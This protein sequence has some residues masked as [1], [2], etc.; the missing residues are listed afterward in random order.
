MAHVPL[1]TI[2]AKES[3]LG[4]SDSVFALLGTWLRDSSSNGDE[5]EADLT[6]LT[7]QRRQA[8]AANSPP[9]ALALYAAQLRILASKLGPLAPAAAFTWGESA[10]LSGASGVSA[11]TS[12]SVG[13]ERAAVVFNLG[14]ALRATAAASPD[15]KAAAKHLA[16]AAHAFAVPP[17]LASANSSTD[18]AP[19]AAVALAAICLADAQERFF[20]KA[21]A[22][23]LSNATVAKLA[24]GTAEMYQ[25]AINALVAATGISFPPIWISV[26]SAKFLFYEAVAAF[27]QSRVVEAGEG[28]IVG[29]FGLEVGY[30]RV[31]ITSLTRIEN[32]LTAYKIVLLLKLESLESKNVVNFLKSEAKTLLEEIM[33]ISQSAEKDNNVICMIK[34]RFCF[35]LPF[36]INTY[37]PID[38]EIVPTA[39]ELPPIQ[40]AKLAKPDETPF[41]TLIPPSAFKPLFSS[42]MPAALSTT[43]TEYIKARDARI[44]PTIEILSAAAPSFRAAIA[45]Q[46]LPD[47]IDAL[48]ETNAEFV[49]YRLRALAR[50]VDVAQIEAAMREVGRLREAAGKAVAAGVA[51]LDLEEVEDGEVQRA[52]TAASASATASA[53]TAALGYGNRGGGAPHSIPMRAQVRV[54]SRVL[55][56]GLRETAD[57]YSD[58][59][60]AAAKSDQV[61]GS[62]VSGV[63]EILC[64][65]VTGD[66]KRDDESSVLM[67]VQRL[68][69]LSQLNA[70]TFEKVDEVVKLR[71]VLKL[72][73]DVLSK[74][75]SL[76]NELEVLK[77]SDD[78]AT[79][80]SEANESDANFKPDAFIKQELQK[81]DSLIQA[82]QASL[83][84]QDDIMKILTT[85]SAKFTEWKKT[86]ALLVKRD[87]LLEEH[88]KAS[89]MFQEIM[90]NL[91]GAIKFYS[92]FEPITAKFLMNCKDYCMTRTIEKNEI[93]EGLQKQKQ[94]VPVW[95]GNDIQKF[96]NVFCF[97]LMDSVRTAKKT[98]R[99]AMRT[100]LRAVGTEELERQSRYATQVLLASQ[101]WARASSVAV[102]LSTPNNEVQ[103]DTIVKAALESGRRVFVPRCINRTEMQMVLLESMTALAALKTNSLGIR[104]PALDENN[105]AVVALSTALLGVDLVVVPG[106]AFDASGARLGHGRGYYDRFLVKLRAFNVENGRQYSPAI[107]LALA[108]QFLD[109]DIPC[110]NDDVKPDFIVSTSTPIPPPF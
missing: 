11:V 85:R 46:R 48:A 89:T 51:A 12:P 1:L 74:L 109:H 75:S 58:K 70:A 42:L 39:A 2:A 24:K 83:K 55:T 56:R 41:D 105:D 45:A 94:Q 40:P 82:S 108:E 43:V 80:L 26:L 59:L 61:V 20:R 14:A 4:D 95:D 77:K 73:N 66:D 21:V 25:A 78:I 91:G 104:E 29:K 67:L 102:Y 6:A 37:F 96:T 15:H 18:F 34:P 57:A 97:V 52:L 49:T 69:L 8:L 53:A 106:L 31:A 7:L 16:M 84:S 13:F 5:T 30:L 110:N 107:A 17:A 27:R 33:P 19:T 64:M 93:L 81:Y 38:M 92:E 23:A 62:K 32:D 88:I 86:N 68:D 87:Q 9:A 36:L 35:Q 98:V 3:V 54:E 72:M 44:S 99:T 10:T 65:L 101:A 76:L 63:W 90:A 71:G 79:K 28:K 100:K 47:A 103:T 50:G 60:R 22:D